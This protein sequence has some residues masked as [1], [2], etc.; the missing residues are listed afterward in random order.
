MFALNSKSDDFDS[1]D[2]IPHRDYRKAIKNPMFRRKLAEVSVDEDEDNSYFAGILNTIAEH[3]VG[4][5]PLILGNHPNPSVNDQVEDRWLEWCTMNGIGSAIRQIRRGAARTGIGIGIPYK[6]E[7]TPENPVGFRIKTVSSLRLSS[8]QKASIEDRIYDGIEYDENWD[9]IKIYI[10]D[11]DKIDPLEYDVKDILFWWKQTYEDMNVGVPECGPAFCLFPAIKRIL[12]ATVIGEEFKA[13]IP[14]AVELDSNVYSPSDKS[15]VP[16][17]KYKYEPG[18][19]PT[20]PPGTKLNGINVNGQSEDRTKLIHMIVAAAA[21]CVSMPKNLA[22]GDSSNSN[23]A[24]AAIDI[25]PW[26]N[27]VTIDRNDFE[28]VIRKV[29]R[30]WKERGTLVSGY[31]PIAARNSFSYDLNYTATF[32]HPDPAKRA[33][34]RSIDLKSGSTTL[35]SVFT[36]QGK[37]P[38]RELDREARTLGIAREELNELI[39][40]Q[41]LGSNY[42]EE[43]RERDE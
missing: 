29:F 12:K 32:E 39:I 41:R 17:G 34:A 25:Q 42:N 26:I 38:R 22:L 19:V 36:A 20:L 11:K 27:R 18:W 2:R 35:Y 15:E 16:V 3:C 9:P 23:M 8:P 31:I 37:N 5:T 10:S 43:E 24:T 40:A 7:P 30:M 4:A 6:V 21:R 33:T 13:S 14:L 28:P 1:W